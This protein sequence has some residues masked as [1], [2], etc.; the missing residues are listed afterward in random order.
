[1]GEDIDDCPYASGAACAACEAIRFA[2]VTPKYVLASFSGI[3]AC[4]GPG[5]SEYNGT[6]LLTQDNLLPCTW[7]FDTGNALI[8]F[9]AG[10]QS[11][12]I[13]QKHFGFPRSVFWSGLVG[14]CLDEFVNGWAFCGGLN[15]GFGGVGLISWGCSIRP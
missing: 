15:A 10:V 12:L 6:Y 4:P 14:E 7:R 13:I 1:M 11:E 3:T 5:P 8:T 2:G 9:V